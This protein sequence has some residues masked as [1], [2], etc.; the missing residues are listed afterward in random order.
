MNDTVTEFKKNLVM[1]TAHKHFEAQGYNG[2]Q[3]DKIAKE[4]GIGVGTIYSM[5]DSKEGLFLCWLFYLMDEAYEELKK[6][7]EIEI[8]P[9]VQLEIFVGYKLSYYEKNKSI[10]RDYMQNNQLFLKNTA[11]RAENPM[12]KIYSLVSKSIETLFVQE[13]IDKNNVSNDFFLLAY[14]LDSLVNSYIER[15]VEFGETVDFTT[16]TKEVVRM[17]LNTIRAESVVYEV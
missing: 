12:R 13:N 7:F 10:L 14:I 17:F 8:S 5:F 6:L 1:Q 16:K 2:V 3:V 15:F 11:R 4:L 9:L